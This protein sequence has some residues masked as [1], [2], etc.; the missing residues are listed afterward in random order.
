MKT[1]WFDMD[2]TLCALYDVPNWLDMLRNNDPTPYIQAK[3]ML[4]M[5]RLA[6]LLHKVQAEGWR[7]GIVSWLSKVPDDDYDLAVTRAKKE[8][9]NKH[10]TSVGW[11]EIH[12]V[13]HGTPKTDFINSTDDILFDDEEKNRDLWAQLAHAYGPEYIIEVLSEVV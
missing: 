12:I 9:L 10:L 7:I 11:D 13:A 1:I 8:W 3:P 6:R 4:N 2:G 5:S